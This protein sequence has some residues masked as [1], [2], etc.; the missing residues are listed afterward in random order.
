[1][2]EPV[3]SKLRDVQMLAC[4][5]GAA[6]VLAVGACGGGDSGSVEVGDCIDDGNQ[7]VDCGSSSATKELVSDQ[8]AEDAIACLKI[9]DKPQVEVTVGDKTF[10]AEKQ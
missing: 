2:E 10:C 4:L 9:G 8:S 3:N 7:V 5:V 1:M 6:L